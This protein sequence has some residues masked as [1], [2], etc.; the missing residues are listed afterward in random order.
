MKKGST[1]FLKGVV[2]LIGAVVFVLCI[3]I[4]HPALSS[5]QEYYRPLLLGMYVPAIPFFLA[6]HQSLKLLNY[7]DKNKAFSE[8][9]VKALQKIKL[10]AASVSTLYAL[11]MPY[12]FYV[13]D[14]DDAPG[15]VAIGFVIIFTSVVVA[16]FA[17]VLERLLQNAIDIKSENDL[18]V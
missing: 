14:K 17:A 3:L 4:L 13:A 16:T 18:T 11:G 8:L 10:C 12:I 9:S 5:T 2:V 7:I 1:L 15:L 6:L